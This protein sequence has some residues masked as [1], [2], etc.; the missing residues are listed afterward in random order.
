MLLKSPNII[1]L[2]PDRAVLMLTDR[3]KCWWHSRQFIFQCKKR[4]R[5]LVSSIYD[6]R[7]HRVI[8]NSVRPRLFL[9]PVDAWRVSVTF[10]GRWWHSKVKPLRARN[11]SGVCHSRQLDCT[12]K[13]LYLFG[14]TRCE[15]ENCH[16]VHYKNKKGIALKSWLEWQGLQYLLVYLMKYCIC[17]R[18]FTR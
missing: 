11:M 10:L 2:T 15:R 8:P 4:E 1:F 17:E 14:Q 5:E 3:K 12:S 7:S 18:N 6:G 13:Y 16:F 9:S